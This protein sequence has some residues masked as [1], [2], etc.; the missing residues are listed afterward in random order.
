MICEAVE[1]FPQSSVAVQVLATL[2][3]PVQAP[4][5]V[6]SLLVNVKSLPHASVAVAVA[7]T[8]V[9]GQSIVVSPGSAA[10]T[11]AVTS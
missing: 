4:G 3:D 6:T 2:Y 7:K 5:V 11:G 10:K 1:T 8:G 9:E